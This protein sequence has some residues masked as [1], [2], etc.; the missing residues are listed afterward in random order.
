MPS[1]LH[2]EVEQ[3]PKKTLT[4]RISPALHSRVKAEAKRA[5]MSINEYMVHLLKGGNPYAVTG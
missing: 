3:E 1:I 2:K 5:K 4:I